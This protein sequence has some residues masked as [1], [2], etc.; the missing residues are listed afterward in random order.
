MANFQLFQS[1]SG[2][3][4]PGGVRTSRHDLSRTVVREVP[5]SKSLTPG[6]DVIFSK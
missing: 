6:H 5:L 2:G 3:S 1:I 4:A